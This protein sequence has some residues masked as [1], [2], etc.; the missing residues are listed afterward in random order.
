MYSYAPSCIIAKKNTLEES[1][2]IY[3]VVNK[4]QKAF[5]QLYDLFGSLVFNLAL[6]LLQN[7][8]DAEEVSQ[9]IFMEVHKKIHLFKGESSLKTWIYRIA[10]NKSMEKIRYNKRKKRFGL[11]VSFSDNE[12]SLLIDHPSVA[13]HNK[14][15]A[16]LLFGEMQK[17]PDNQRS[18]FTLH[19]VEGM[20]Y[21]EIAEIME[22]SLSS[23]E[24][25]IFR[26][27]SNLKKRIKEKISKNHG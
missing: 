12:D 1:A 24:S 2:L 17:L 21:K 7:Q 8:E 13:E 14:S 9:D 6:N 20:S 22:T 15:K 3:H 27:K 19:H 4:D 18:A 16:N 26:A 25:L 5:S 23:V 10:L 11:F